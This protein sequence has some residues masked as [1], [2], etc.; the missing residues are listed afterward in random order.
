MIKKR[1]INQYKEDQKAISYWLIGS[2]ERYNITKEILAYL[3]IYDLL[4]L[5]LFK[6]IKKINL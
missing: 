1:K 2:I 6:K 3:K 5:Q 4:F